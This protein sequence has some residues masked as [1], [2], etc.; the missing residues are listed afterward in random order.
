MSGPPLSG[1]VHASRIILSSSFLPP[2]PLAVAL[3]LP[4]VLTVQSA[5]QSPKMLMAVLLSLPALMLVLMVSFL[6]LLVRMLVL[7]VVFPF[8][9]MRTPLAMSIAAPEMT[10]RRET[11]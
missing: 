1:G 4:S 2:F 11:S 7:I 8:L 5:A 10:G 6:L 9:P 3:V